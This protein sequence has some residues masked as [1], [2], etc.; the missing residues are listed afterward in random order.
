MEKSLKD[1]ETIRISKK[2]DSPLEGTE[3][4]ITIMQILTVA[5]VDSPGNFTFE[6]PEGNVFSMEVSRRVAEVLRAN[7][8]NSGYFV[9]KDESAEL[10]G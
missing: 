3:T 6:N 7:L 1:S 9:L 4:L 5:N 10:D 8:P 2:G